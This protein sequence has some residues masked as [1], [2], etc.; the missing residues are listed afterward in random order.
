MKTL[1]TSTAVAAAL[2]LATP[3]AT[4][5]DGHAMVLDATAAAGLAGERIY[6][7]DGALDADAASD[8]EEVGEIDEI[9]LSPTGELEAVVAEVGGFLGL[10]ERRVAIDPSRIAMLT[11]TDGEALVVANGTR[12]E[13]EAAEAWSDDTPYVMGRTEHVDAIDYEGLGQTTLGGVDVVE[14][15]EGAPVT[16]LNDMQPE[17]TTTNAA[18]LDPGTVVDNPQTPA[19]AVITARGAETTTGSAARGT[20]YDR[21][22]T[23]V[24]EA[25]RDVGEVSLNGDVVVAGIEDLDE[26][27]MVGTPE[28]LAE[29][30][31]ARAGTDGIVVA[32][33]DD[34][35]VTMAQADGDG[36]RTDSSIVMER[37]A[38]DVVVAQPLT[39]AQEDLLLAAPVIER[40]G[41]AALPADEILLGGWDDIPLYGPGDDRIGEIEEVREVSGLGHP[42]AILEVG[43]FLGLGEHTVAM[44]MPSLTI[45]RD[46]DG[47]IRAYIDA[48]EEQLEGLPEFEG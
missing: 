11:G 33:D 4:L 48:T 41:Y 22:D 23:I 6:L 3:T 16:P 46:A 45:L 42:L 2:A 17:G 34:A 29:G 9:V 43:G 27:P 39:E 10:G 35:A 20:D 31:V 13:L 12:A 40:D 24:E 21:G 25:R 32:D 1:L 7:T 47:D 19:T 15:R 44:P 5:A 18:I 14:N 37:E 38:N 30:G 28:T 8:W 36:T 26:T